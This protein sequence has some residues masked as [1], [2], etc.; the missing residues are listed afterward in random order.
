M[1]RLKVGVIGCGT[2]AQIMHLPHLRQLAELYE[3]RALCDLSPSVLNAV[4]DSYRVD[5]RYQA[6][7]DLLADGIE[8]VLVLTPGS[9]AAV[10]LAAVQAGAHVLVEKPMCFTLREADELIAAAEQRGRT[11]MVGYMKRYDPGYRYAQ[12]ALP[13]FGELRYIQINTLHPAEAPFQEIHPLRR[14]GDIP[15]EMLEQLAAEKTRLAQE[16]L[17]PVSQIVQTIYTDVILGSLIHDVNALRG[18]VGEPEAVEFTR[19]WPPEQALPIVNTV[20]RHR[21]GLRTVYTWAYLPDYHDYFEEIALMGAGGRL[22]I[23]FPSPYLRHFPTP[24]MVERM[25]GGAATKQ[26]V[27]ASYAEAFREELIHFHA[28]VTSGKRPLTDGRDARRDLE[29]LQQVVAAWG[30]VGLGGEAGAQLDASGV[31]RE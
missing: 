30:P 28:C 7:Q 31:V 2:I 4:G 19:V 15:R 24:V 26:Q 11:L 8:A 3:I 20:F 21:E 22:R 18:L 16:A 13:E 14:D 9:H 12:A 1:P 29:L 5:R 10:V 6:Y 27:I 17:G 23:H 25:Q